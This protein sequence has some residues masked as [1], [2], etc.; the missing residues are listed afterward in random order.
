MLPI[1]LRLASLFKGAR[2]AA[3]AATVAKNNPVSPPRLPSGGTGGS[4]N[5][6]KGMEVVPA[7]KH[8]VVQSGGA[9]AR[10]HSSRALEK[11]EVPGASP[12]SISP[13]AT[14]VGGFI[15]GMA[16]DDLLENTEGVGPEEAL[17]IISG[18][19][20]AHAKTSGEPEQADNSDPAADTILPPDT[21]EIDDDVDSTPP[22]VVQTQERARD[23]LQILLDSGGHGVALQ[24]D[25]VKDLQHALAMSDLG[26]WNMMLYHKDGEPQVVD[27]KAGPRTYAAV[28]AYAEDH[29]I[30]LRTMTMAGLIEHAKAYEDPENRRMLDSQPG[31]SARTTAEANKTL[32]DK[33]QTADTFNTQVAAEN[34]EQPQ[35]EGSAPDIKVA[36]APGLGSKV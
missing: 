19:G 18:S 27:G 20:P 5:V 35:A 24:G 1:F 17:E 12:K 2:T 11:P 14:A 10:A 30:D 28:L 9:V 3:P 15:A 6:P 13:S 16:A 36:Q 31:S 23:P 33:G 32:W 26:L 4:G 29:Q 21:D 8:S 34:A 22:P 25:M 7:G